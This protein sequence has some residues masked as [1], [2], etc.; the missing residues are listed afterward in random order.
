MAPS[1]A[2]LYKNGSF[3]GSMQA[4]R[5]ERVD[6]AS[7]RSFEFVWGVNSNYKP[8]FKDIYVIK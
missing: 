6:S 5:V 8:S 4:R 1:R 2:I 3:E 7:L